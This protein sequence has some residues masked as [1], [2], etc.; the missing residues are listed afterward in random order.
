MAGR[1]RENPIEWQTYTPD[2]R[3]LAIR[4]LEAGRWAAWCGGGAPHDGETA[5][6]AINAAITEAASS[7]IPFGPNSPTVKAWVESQAAQVELE[8]ASR[9]DQTIDR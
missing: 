1:C 5:A 4:Q 3:S 6:D 9:H 2:G 7:S 8:A